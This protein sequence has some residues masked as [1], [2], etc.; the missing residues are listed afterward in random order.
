M[1]LNV[2]SLAAL[3]FA[4]AACGDDVVQP[5][6]ARTPDPAA[7]L[8]ADAVSRFV[9][10]F[11]GAVRK[12]FASRVAALGGTVTYMADGAGFAGVSGL[13]A[14]AAAALERQVGIAAVDEDPV[15]QLTDATTYGAAEAADVSVMSIANPAGAFRFSF[16]W[17]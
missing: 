8:Q 11:N 14:A 16:Q 12:D 10:E 2:L 1:K 9:V 6:V 15:V 4:V 3:A 7:A 5:T 17:N 13:S